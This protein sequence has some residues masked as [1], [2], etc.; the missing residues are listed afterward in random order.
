MLPC[1]VFFPM[2]GALA[3]YGAG[4]KNKTA[5]D[6]MANAIVILE[7]AV[8]LYVFCMHHMAWQLRENVGNSFG[9]PSSFRIPGFCGMGIHFAIDGFRVLYG[10]IAAFMWMMSTVFSKEYFIHYRNRN[11]YYFFLLVTLG[12]TMGVFLSSDLY[13]TFIFFEIMSF[14]SYVWVAHDEKAESLRAAETYLAVAVTG[15][16]VMLMGLLLLYRETGTLEIDRLYEACRSIMTGFGKEAEA[17][18]QTV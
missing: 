12:A 4:R 16:L 9:Y 6:Y 5:R 2:V 18:R 14:T 1:L 8:M 10:L 11:R 13:T 3:A 17:G 7:F 15:G